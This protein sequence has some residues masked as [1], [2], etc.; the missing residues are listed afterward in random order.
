VSKSTGV[1]MFVS[2]LIVA[3]AVAAQGMLLD[4]AADKVVTKFQTTS[5]E[6]LKLQKGKPES[7]KEKMAVD[8]L[9]NDAQA[10]KAFFDKI[11]APVLNKMFECGMIP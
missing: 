3:G 2:A 7:E 4:F 10:R 5:C 9:R 6:E 8:F 1:A 11:A